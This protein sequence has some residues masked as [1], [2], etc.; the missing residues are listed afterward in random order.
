MEDGSPEKQEE[1]SALQAVKP[2]R[3][4]TLS[5]L[6]FPLAG[7]FFPEWRPLV[8]GAPVTTRTPSTEQRAAAARSRSPLR[9]LQQLLLL[10]VLHK[11]AARGDRRPPQSS[12]QR[13][14][15]RRLLP[16]PISR[17]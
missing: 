16:R 8:P 2:F 13:L 15:P 3:L 1:R 4:W 6:E 7:E 14:Y 12:P 17:H 5:P 9:Q 11:C 10:P